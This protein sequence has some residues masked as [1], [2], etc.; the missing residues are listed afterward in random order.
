MVAGDGSMLGTRE[1]WKEA[2]VATVGA[3]DGVIPDKRSRADVRYVAVLGGQEEFRVALKAALDAELADDVMHIVWLGDGARENWTMASEL[4]PFAIQILDFMHAVQNGV[5]CAKV[6]LGEGDVGLPLWEERIRQLLGTASVDALIRE[7]LD[8]LPFTT[9][10]EEL[11]ALNRLVGYYRA[12]EKRMRYAEFRE[13]GL[14]IGSGT[15]ESAHKHV[16]QVRMKQAGQRWSLPRGRRMV[17]L[18]ALYRTAG[19][20][21]FHWAVRHALVV[22]QARAH[23]TLPNG[24]RR[25]KHNYVPSPLS[26]LNRAAASN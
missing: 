13:A 15:V 12:N 14:P 8:C 25:A 10:D 11:A 2:K 22:P 26:R 21:R 18:R 4:C 6:L 16:L 19:P 1:G 7:L 3:E 9:T 5:A 20:R 23:A 24:P 17:Q